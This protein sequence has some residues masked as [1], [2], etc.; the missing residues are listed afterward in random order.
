MRWSVQRLLLITS[1]IAEPLD[2]WPPERLRYKT[3][4]HVCLHAATGEAPGIPRGNAATLG[5][6]YK[7]LYGISELDNGALPV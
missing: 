3:P 4:S 6:R 5:P 7:A 1:Q 2:V